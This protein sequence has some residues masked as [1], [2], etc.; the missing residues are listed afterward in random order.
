[1]S[2]RLQVRTYKNEHPDSPLDPT[3]IIN[4]HRTD[5]GYTVAFNV[6]AGYAQ[7]MATSP[8]LRAALQNLINEIMSNPEV[9]TKITPLAL[10]HAQNAL[11]RS[12]K[13]G[14]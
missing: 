12:N 9:F 6:D 2:K 1:M 11:K 3:E 8:E 14:A 5:E 7:L 13:F 10:E 4:I